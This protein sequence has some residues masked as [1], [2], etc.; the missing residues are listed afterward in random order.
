MTPN[1]FRVFFVEIKKMPITYILL[2]TVAISS[3]YLSSRTSKDISFVLATLT[4][5]ICF[6]WGFACA[7]WII[8]LLIVAMLLRLHKFYLPD[9]QGLG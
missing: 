8:Q 5:L 2:L 7:P 3:A 9:G 4:G 6:F 1:Y